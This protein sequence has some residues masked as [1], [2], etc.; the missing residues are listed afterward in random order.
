MPAHG[1]HGMGQGVRHVL[2][3]CCV[4]HGLAAGLQE[5]TFKGR[6]SRAE[7]QGVTRRTEPTRGQGGLGALIVRRGRSA[8]LCM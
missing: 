5:T 7:Q 1:E 3:C 4:L 6:S 2:H 8:A